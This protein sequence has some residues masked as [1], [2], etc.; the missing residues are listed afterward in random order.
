MFPRSAMPEP[1]QCPGPL[2]ALSAFA[3]VLVALSV[4]RFHKTLD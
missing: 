3:V 2:L 4:R 1:A